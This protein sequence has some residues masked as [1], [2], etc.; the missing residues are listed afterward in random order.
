M[1]DKN[2]VKTPAQLQVVLSEKLGRLRVLDARKA[3]R[4]FDSPTPRLKQAAESVVRMALRDTEKPDASVKDRKAF[5]ERKI[6]EKENRSHKH[7]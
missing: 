4:L 5:W 3:M 1:I 2:E 7:N 6:Q